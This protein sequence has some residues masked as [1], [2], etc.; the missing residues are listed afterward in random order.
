MSLYVTVFNCWVYGFVSRMLFNNLLLYNCMFLQQQL[1]FEEY[2]KWVLRHNNSVGCKSYPRSRCA[3][4]KFWVR[5]FAFHYA[6]IFFRKDLPLS[7]K[8]IIR[9]LCPCRGVS[10]PHKRMGMVLNFS[11]WWRSIS[12]ELGMLDK[13]VISVT[14]RSTLTRNS[15][16]C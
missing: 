10:G 1:L 7:M 6:L 4:F 14:P 15:S 2:L 5:V 13:T 9:G 3:V 16:T 8:F 12:E 11:W